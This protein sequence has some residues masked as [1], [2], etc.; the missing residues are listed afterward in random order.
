MNAKF[1][2]SPLHEVLFSPYPPL[3]ATVCPQSLWRL[4]NFGGKIHNFS[5]K[6]F[7]D[8]LRK[9]QRY[10]EKIFKNFDLPW[11]IEQPVGHI[12]TNPRSWG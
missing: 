3:H 5:K 2:L 9:I 12:S 4:L 8:L 11:A 7:N 1:S 6:S 10:F